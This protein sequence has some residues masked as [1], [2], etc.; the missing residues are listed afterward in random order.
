MRSD[1][2]Q[3]RFSYI[4]KPGETEKIGTFKFRLENTINGDPEAPKQGLKV[5]RTYL[6][7]MSSAKIAYR[8]ATD[9]AAET[10]LSFDTIRETR[11]ALVK[12]GYMRER[13]KE[14]SGAILYEIKNDRAP[15]VFDHVESVRAKLRQSETEKKNVARSRT[16][17]SETVPPKKSG[18]NDAEFYGVSPENSVACPPEISGAVPLILGGNTVEHNVEEGEG[19]P[20]PS[21]ISHSALSVV[22]LSHLLD[23]EIITSEAARAA[24]DDVIETLSD[25]MPEAREAIR[26]LWAC[27]KLSKKAAR[28][29]RA[30]IK[31]IED[32]KREG[33]KSL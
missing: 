4:P 14:A 24:P 26:R 17:E 20:A 29:A 23:N 30:V 22:D 1:N 28:D 33:G 13:G 7:F 15:I 12:L 11:N 19:A 9:I 2:E 18:D 32:K 16:R 10:G 31:L 27:G 3:R 25:G 8:S 21:S 6:D 5:M